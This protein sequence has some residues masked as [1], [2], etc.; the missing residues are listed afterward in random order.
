MCEGWTTLE[1]GDTGGQPQKMEILSP[2]EQRHNIEHPFRVQHWLGP[3]IGM[4]KMK[5]N[6]YFHYT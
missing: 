5:H 6:P 2:L 1:D 3:T 4:K